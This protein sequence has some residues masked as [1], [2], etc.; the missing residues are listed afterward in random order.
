M[1]NKANLTQRFLTIVFASTL[2][3]VFYLAFHTEDAAAQTPTT[4]PVPATPTVTPTP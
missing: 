2:L 3:I 4:T 1:R